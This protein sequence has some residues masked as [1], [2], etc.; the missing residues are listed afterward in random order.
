[1]KQ[2]NLSF[3][4]GS[5]KSSEGSIEEL[6]GWRGN[7]QNLEVSHAYVQW[8]FPNYFSSMFNAHSAALT[9]DEAAVFRTDSVVAQRYYLS[10]EIFMDFLGLQ[11]FDKMT[12]AIGRQKGGEER[13]YAALVMH[14]HNQLRMRRILASLA[15]CGFRR[16]MAPLVHHLE[17][18]ITGSNSAVA[19]P[20]D[21]TIYEEGRKGEPKLKSL[22]HSQ[23][24]L[25]TWLQYVDGDASNFA[26][27]TKAVKGD[28]D[29]SVFFSQ[30]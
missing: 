27:N 20:K 21:F 24:C 16:Y 5:L 14:P 10:Y 18:E 11:I 8:F 1:M 28:E 12:G 9:P 17:W 25:D 30:S 13:L 19:L 4:R 7:Y 29:D 3:Y 2:P 6:H 22:R 23:G 15:V 26:Q